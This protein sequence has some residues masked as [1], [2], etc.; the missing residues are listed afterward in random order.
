MK[1][2]K[3]TKLLCAAVAA[4][5]IINNEL[6]ASTITT[7][8]CGWTPT[9][10]IQKINCP[11]SGEVSGCQTGTTLDQNGLNINGQCQQTG[12]LSS[13]CEDSGNAIYGDFQVI[14]YLCGF[15]NAA[16]CDTTPLFAPDNTWG[17]IEIYWST[18]CLSKG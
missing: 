12:D 5:F 4:L 15:Y 18:P 2:N 8:T 11:G 17:W 6:K 9:S 13:A 7:I 14:T 10:Q 3:T 1:R 16:S